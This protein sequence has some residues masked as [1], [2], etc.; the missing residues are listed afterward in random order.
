MSHNHKDKPIVENIAL[1]L[2]DV[3]GCDAVFFDSWSI[4]PGEGVIDKMNEGLSKCQYFFFF[5]SEN[6]LQSSMVKLEWQNALMKAS[7]RQLRFITIRMDI[8]SMPALLTQSLY[9]DLFSNGLDVALSQII[10]VVQGANTFQPQH[11]RCS[12][13]QAVCLHE[14]QKMR[15]I[16]KAVYY[17]EVVPRI[18][19]KLRAMMIEKSTSWKY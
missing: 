13:L 19:V 18:A 5:V 6:S 16:I 2:K 17:L 15:I 7:N 4:Q 1:R 10:Q 11:A 3:F 14:H 12:N 9:I 8:S